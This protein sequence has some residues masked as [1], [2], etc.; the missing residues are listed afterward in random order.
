MGTDGHSS[1]RH[2]DTPSIELDDESLTVFFHDCV[3]EQS[4]GTRTKMKEGVGGDRKAGKE[5]IIDGI[6]S[7]EE[8]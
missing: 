1:P 7:G 8:R 5:R 6:G 2:T 3:G 4:V